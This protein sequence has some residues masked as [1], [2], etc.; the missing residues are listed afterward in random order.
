MPDWYLLHGDNQLLSRQRLTNLTTTFKSQGVVEQVNLDGKKVELGEVKQALE[1]G[2]LFGD[3]RLVVLEELLS[4]PDSKRK[5]EV[6]DYLASVK[7]SRLVIVWE[8]KE[9]KVGN[10]KKIGKKFQV[11]IFKVPALVFKFLDSVGPGN[12]KQTLGLLSQLE[13]KEPEMIFYLLAQRIRQLIIAK[14]LG[15]KG[16]ADLHGWQ[17]SR[18]INQAAQFELDQIVRLYQNLLLIDYQQ[19]T[20][21]SPFSLKSNLDL[22]VANL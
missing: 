21:Q 15:K 18:L 20:G 11:E 19:K 7:S 2:S 1:A 5:K 16:L 22:L 8:K 12:Q 13:D 4:A 3:Q 9:I 14:D 10:L 17:Q 6:I